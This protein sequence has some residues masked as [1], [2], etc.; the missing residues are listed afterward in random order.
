MIKK[1]ISHRKKTMKDSTLF[2]VYFGI[3]TRILI[4]IKGMLTASK[5]GVN[6]KMDSYL[7][8]L[9]AIMI[10]TK[11][12]GDGLIVA[13]IPLLRE[14]QEK[15]GTERRMD[16]TNNLINTTILASFMFVI[17]G[18]I[19]APHII[20]AHG[21]GFTGKSLGEA[22][23]LF[24]LGLPMV[25]LTWVRSVGG[26]FLQS[27]HA[28]KAGAKGGVS[29]ALVYIIYLFF[30]SEKY[31]L[32][33]LMVAGTIAIITQIYIVLKAME[34][35]GFKYKWKI[36]F[37]DKY[38]GKVMEYL[39]PILLGIGIYEINWGV[40]NAIASTQAL[41]SI[42]ELNYANEVIQLFLGLFIAAIVTV[43]F[44]IL[45]ENYNKKTCYIDGECD[46]LNR[47]LNYGINLILTISI[48]VSII[49]MTMA[50]PIIKIF[51]ERGAFDT[52]ASFFT[53][54]ALVYY[55]LGLT[56]MAIMP[57]IARAYYA[58][59]DVNT[60]ITIAA[61]ALLAN[62]VLD[63][64]LIRYM[65]ARGLAL[66]T[67]I[68][69]ILAVVYGLH[70]LNKILQFTQN[71]S[72]RKTILELLIAGLMM[73]VSIIITNGAISIMMNPCFLNNMITVSVSSLVGIF[74]YSK[75]FKAID[76]KL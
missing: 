14:I 72:I 6:Y 28:F 12:V 48:P 64:I 57:L 52:S 71:K 2:I 75:I 73:A 55:A 40:D 44:P 13:L 74:I 23:L 50:E 10:L 67:S 46:D 35:K 3:A 9:G 33:G 58:I 47:E 76:L 5:I 38:L 16:Y 45:A 69:I 41:G 49:L 68:S 31:G 56:A 66:G 29:N 22:I 63:L 24:K 21:P 1:E 27:D 54:Q 42:A 18:Y 20:R 15:H 17:I 7:L 60:P 70:D 61:I 43:T 53:S 51:F 30:F 4:F 19:W 65:G 34:V 8:A 25:T 37:K 32:K 62:V 11:I 59:H 39:L 26:G 36:D